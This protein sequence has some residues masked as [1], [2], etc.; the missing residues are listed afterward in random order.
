[1]EQSGD[2][3]ADCR[4][5][6]APEH[7]RRWKTAAATSLAIGRTTLYRYLSGE[8]PVPAA[9]RARLAALTKQPANPFAGRTFLGEERMTPEQHIA[10]ASRPFTGAEYIESL[11]DGREVYING[12]RVRDVTTHPGFRNSV[13]SLARLYDALHEPERQNVLTC[14]TDNGSAGFTHRYFRVARSPEEL[15]AQQVSIAEWAR[16]TYG[17][18]GRTPDYKAAL[19]NTLGANAEYYG[20]FAGN[21]RA[22]YK[23]AKEAV[24]F[25]NDAIVN[26]PVDRGGPTSEVKDVCVT[27]EKVNDAGVVVWSPRLGLP[28]R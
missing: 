13:R 14:P 20:Q 27:M 3:A 24:L 11:K 21:A 12:E 19:M 7:G 15:K 26:Q 28:A 17:W 22:W 9:V 10:D 18:M 1:M 4:R 5:L 16:L 25:M 23:R 6:F 2:F 8:Q